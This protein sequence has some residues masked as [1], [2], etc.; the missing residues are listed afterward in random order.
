M[1][2]GAGGIK[3]LTFTLCL[4]RFWEEGTAEERIVVEKGEFN[5]LD[6]RRNVGREKF[7][8]GTRAKLKS[9]LSKRDFWRT[10]TWIYEKAVLYFILV[11]YIYM[12]CM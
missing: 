6:G 4:H 8:G 9:L 10:G 3:N 5:G 1:W 11:L 12:G 7:F 2:S